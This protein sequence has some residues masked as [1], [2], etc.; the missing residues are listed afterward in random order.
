M[1]MGN[2]LM[3]ENEHD[4]SNR[5]SSAFDNRPAEQAYQNYPS[6][7]RPAQYVCSLEELDD[8]S[9]HSG[10]NSARRLDFIHRNKVSLSPK[11]KNSEEVKFNQNV[12][13]GETIPDDKGEEEKEVTKKSKK[14]FNPDLYRFKYTYNVQQ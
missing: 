14:K 6:A 11:A 10:K 13:T 1:S 12:S 8:H 3:H 7:L 4:L 5:F 9:R 2:G